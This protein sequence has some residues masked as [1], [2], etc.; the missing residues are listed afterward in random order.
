MFATFCYNDAF[1]ASFRVNGITLNKKVKSLKEIK[2]AN[3]IHQSL[4][5]SCGAAGLSTILHYYLNE[6][7]SEKDIIT[8]LLKS[9]DLAKVQRRKG[10]SLLDLKKF[11]EAKGYKAS[12]YCNDTG[13]GQW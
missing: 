5:Y 12:G 1:A 4:D 13:S 9:T 6:P 8:G 11:S 3:I 10:F 7:V 2:S